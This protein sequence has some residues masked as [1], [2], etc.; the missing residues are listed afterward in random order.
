VVFRVAVGKANGVRIA[1]RD[2]LARETKAGRVEMMEAPIDTFVRTDCQRQFLK[3]QIAA[4]GIR[5]IKGTTKL[6]TVAQ[7]GIDACAQQEIEGFVG[8]KLRG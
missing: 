5:C 7:L 8:K 2:G 1:V 3:Q 4:I 6:E